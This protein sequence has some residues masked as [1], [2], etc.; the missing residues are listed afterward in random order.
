MERNAT[1]TA[2]LGLAPRR[3][4]M[5]LQDL[6]RDYRIWQRRRAAYARTYQ[7]LASLSDRD[8]QDIAISRLNIRAVASEAAR[9]AVE[10]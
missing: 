3:W 7:E 5:V 2:P 6:G 4:R 8:L 10:R 9:M 1:L